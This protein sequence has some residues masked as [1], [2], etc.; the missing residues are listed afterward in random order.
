MDA[1]IT[2]PHNNKRKKRERSTPTTRAEKRES[3]GYEDLSSFEKK[4]KKNKFKEI[5]PLLI[6]RIDIYTSRILDFA[7]KARLEQA[8]I[9]RV[10]PIVVLCRKKKNLIHLSPLF[11]GGLAP[12][13]IYFYSSNE[14]KRWRPRQVCS[15]GSI[16]KKKRKKPKKPFSFFCL[17][18]IKLCTYII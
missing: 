11:F 5:L 6:C 17:N 16:K 9:L 13:C 4:K 15:Q 3:W 12:I 14:K 8:H 10:I 7:G 1:Q 18:Q 2:C